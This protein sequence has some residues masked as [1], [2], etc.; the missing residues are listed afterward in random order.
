MSSLAFAAGPL[1]VDAKTRTAY[2]YDVREAVP[3]F[4]DRGNLG[5]T[6]DFS[7]DPPRQVKFSNWYGKRMVEKGFGDW[8]SVATSSLRTTVRGNFSLLGLPNINATNITQI[9]GKSNGRGIYVVFDED[10]SI[11]SNFFGVGPSVLGIATPQFGIEGTTIITESWVVINGS[12]IDPADSKVEQYQGVATHEFGHSLGL[13]HTQTNGS[14]YFFADAVGPA[15]CSTL[16]YANDLTSADVETM[17]PFINPTASSGTGRAQ[18]NIH[19]LDTIAAISDLYPG[20]GWPNGYGTINGKIFDLDG[21]S[22]L[23]G[24]NVIARNVTDPFVDSVSAISGQMTQGELGPDGSFTLH[25]LKPGSKYVVYAD[26][27]MV[28]GFSTPPLWFLPGAE[29]FFKPK[30]SKPDYDPCK[31]KQISASA[32]SKARADIAF[33]HIPGSPVLY[34]LGYGASITGISGDG[35]VAVGNYGLGGPAFRWTAKTGPISLNVASDGGFTSISRNGKY[36]STNM[37]DI[38]SFSSLGTFRWDASKGWVRVTPVGSCGSDTTYNYGVSNSGAVYGLAYTTNDCRSY[39]SFRWTPSTGTLLFPS[40]TTKPDGSPA[41]GRPNQ[42]SADGSTIVGWEEDETGSR[43]GVVW[44]NGVPSV[45]RNENGEAVSE[46]YSTSSNGQI[47]GGGLF[48]GQEPAGNGWRRRVD[49]SELEYFAPLSEDASPINPYAMSKDGKVMAGFS[50]NPFFSFNPAPFLWTKELGPAN[51]NE[52]V[53][54]QGTSAEQWFSL[55]TPLAMSDDGTVIGGW[56]LG[57][58]FFAGWLLDMKTVFVCHAET[59]GTPTEPQT[60]S[61]PFPKDFDQH[62]AH[63]DTVGRCPEVARH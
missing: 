44:R 62:L 45:I 53:K 17:Y 48:S 59:S 24:V 42:I 5:I 31:F 39:K 32:G 37:F 30:T 29:K 4:Y 47:I 55:W 27:L 9:I 51:L 35:T 40:A 3:I 34:Q 49:S 46:A 63:G 33:D 10:G 43:I 11:M 19:T 12:A 54:S 23:T 18:A 57:T 25:G 13:A 16:P 38:N 26:A 20:S 22:E 2:A 50:G 60:L 52:F 61:V 15:S 41:N 58:Q 14:A 56:G 36:I 7:V 21:K 28:G 6:Y 8:G 1:I